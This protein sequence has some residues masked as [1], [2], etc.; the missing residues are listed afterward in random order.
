MWVCP[1]CVLSE[2]F[3]STRR[4]RSLQ[5][6][7]LLFRSPWVCQQHLMS[8]VLL[9]LASSTH[10]TGQSCD[11]WGL[12]GVFTWRAVCRIWPQVWEFIAQGIT[13]PRVWLLAALQWPRGELVPGLPFFQRHWLLQRGFMD[14]QNSGCCVLHIPIFWVF[15]R[16][17]LQPGA[18]FLSEF[19]YVCV[20]VD[21]VMYF[22]CTQYNTVFLRGRNADWPRM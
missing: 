5:N 8:S 11:G 13:Q 21:S 6:V 18:E 15:P 4:E 2:N 19:M 7:R 20:Y 1:S 12:T 16:L 10:F 9:P 14:T 3:E 17:G 22:C